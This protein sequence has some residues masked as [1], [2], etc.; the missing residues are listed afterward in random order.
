[1]EWLIRTRSA[2]L[3]CQQHLS[4][5]DSSGA[6][7]EAFLAQYLLIVLCAEIQEEIYGVVELRAKKCG[8]DEVCAFALASSRKILR[9]VKINELS[10]FIGGF[11]SVRKDRFMQLLDAREVFQYNS[12]IDNRHSVAHKRGAQVTISDVVAIIDSAAKVLNAAKSALVDEGRE[13]V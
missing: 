11:G 4:Q 1:M 10:G 13:Q 9:S 7:V 8:D 6:E 3:E 12:A 2:L 5:T